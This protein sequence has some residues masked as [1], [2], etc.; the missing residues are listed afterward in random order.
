[1]EERRI[2]HDAGVADDAE[3][4]DDAAGRRP[5]EDLDTPDRA[6]T[7]QE[8]Q[9]RGCHGAPRSARRS[10]AHRVHVVIFTLLRK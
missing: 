9:S 6:R 8:R 1:V 5:S 2:P 7:T 3:V 4:E 10:A